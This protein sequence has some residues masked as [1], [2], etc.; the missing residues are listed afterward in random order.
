[1]IDL[2]YTISPHYHLADL[3]ERLVFKMGAL[4]ASSFA[5]ISTYL[6]GISLV[7][8]TA[9]FFAYRENA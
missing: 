4:T 6:A 7:I 8:G 1:M 5:G 9:A 2:I 3:T